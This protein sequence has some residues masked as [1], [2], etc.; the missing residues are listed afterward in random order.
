VSIAHGTPFGTVWKYTTLGDTLKGRVELGNFPATMQ[1]TPDGEFLYVVNFNLH[2]DPVP[3]SVSVVATEAMVEVARTTTCVM[4]HG[5]RVNPQGTKQYSACMMDDV[6]VEIDTR[7]FGASRH[8]M[9]TKGK[10]HGDAGPPHREM[11]AG[12]HQPHDMSGHGMTPP[13]PG[14]DTCSPTWAQPSADGSKVFV[15]CNKSSDIVEID[16]ATWRMTRRIPAGPGVYNLAVSGDGR[17]LIG[18]NKRGQ[19]VSIIEIATGRELAR[20]PTRR[21]VVHGAVVSPDN[22]YAFISVEGIGSEPGTVEMI[23]LSTFKTIATVDV[24]QQAG[25]IDFWRMEAP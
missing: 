4:P 11:A 20:V 14:D 5:S 9:V 16:V 23:D 2:G 25:G 7:T 12:S 24:G 21:K 3:S 19:S 15:A 17:L 13:K 6:I 18:T 1:T 10:E 8:F 22:R